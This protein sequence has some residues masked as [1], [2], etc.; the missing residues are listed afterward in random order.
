MA[1]FNEG[2]IDKLIKSKSKPSKSLPKYRYETTKAKFNVGDKEDSSEFSRNGS[3]KE[4]LEYFVDLL[5]DAEINGSS[6]SLSKRNLNKIENDNDTIYVY[7]LKV[8]EFVPGNNESGVYKCIVEKIEASGT[9]IEVLEKYGF[10]IIGSDNASNIEKA[11]KSEYN[12]VVSIARAAIKEAK[13]KFGKFDHIVCGPSYYNS[14]KDKVAND[15]VEDYISSKWGST[16]TIVRFW[17]TDDN[18]ISAEKFV[19]NFMKDKVKSDSSISGSIY[20]DGDKDEY[21]IGYKSSLK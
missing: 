18:T 7:K 15:D 2:F 6:I 12:K 5:Y 21:L 4:S 13:S 9:C 3:P 8:N 10:H 11:K 20:D 19:F 14:L 16:I 1:I 17:G